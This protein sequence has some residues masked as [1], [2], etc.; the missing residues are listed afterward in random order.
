[1]CVGA[2]VPNGPHTKP[3]GP[4]SKA[5]LANQR[6]ESFS[7]TKSQ[8]NE[9]VVILRGDARE[10]VRNAHAWAFRPKRTLCRRNG[11]DARSE[12]SPK[13]IPRRTKERC[14]GLNKRRVWETLVP[15]GLRGELARRAKRGRPGPFVSFGPRQKTPARGRNNL[16]HTLGVDSSSSQ[17]V[18]SI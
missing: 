2:V 15:G 11:N 7:K 3:E 17:P 14:T 16:S 5:H 18:S 12:V 13:D 8:P 6:T 1:M 4:T 9:V 10:R